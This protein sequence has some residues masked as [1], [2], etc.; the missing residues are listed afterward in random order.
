[1][2]IRCTYY[3]CSKWATN[4]YCHE[5]ASLRESGGGGV[6]V[7]FLGYGMGIVTTLG[8]QWAFS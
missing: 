5:H 8:L 7:L 4:A 2:R 6:L 3:G 1:M